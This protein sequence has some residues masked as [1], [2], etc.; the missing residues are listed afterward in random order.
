MVPLESFD[1][2]PLPSLF[3][4][5]KGLFARMSSLLAS[6]LHLQGKLLDHCRFVPFDLHRSIR[7]TVRDPI[8]GL[9]ITSDPIPKAVKILAF[10]LIRFGNAGSVEGEVFFV[11]GLCPSIQD[12][13]DSL[14]VRGSTGQEEENRKRKGKEISSHSR[15]SEA[16]LGWI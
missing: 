5:K 13:L 14:F 8:K 6:L 9:K 3:P 1:D 12:L 4:Q 7:A 11:E 15:L 16:P 10:I 2:L